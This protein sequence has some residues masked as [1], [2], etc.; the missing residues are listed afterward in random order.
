MITQ[1][2]IDCI[3]KAKAY[4]DGLV[5]YTQETNDDDWSLEF[6]KDWL[7]FKT[8]M[9]LAFKDAHVFGNKYMHEKLKI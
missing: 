4:L 5:K 2:D 1:E 8:N 9:S 6:L 7:H 3:E